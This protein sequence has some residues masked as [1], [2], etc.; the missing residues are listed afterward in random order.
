MEKPKVNIPSS[1]M[2]SALTPQEAMLERVHKHRKL[3]IGLP[4]ERAFQENRI[5]LVP[6]AVKALTKAGQRILIEQG[7]GEGAGFSDFE[8]SEAGAEIAYSGQQVFEAEVILKVAPPS[9]EEIELC[10]PGQIIISPLHLP[11]LSDEFLYRLKQ[12][13]VTALAMEYMKDSSNIFPFVRM[14]SEM[15]GISA[16]QTAAELLSVSQG[17]RGVLL[18]GISGVPPAKVIILGAGV[19]A[20]VA[21]RVALGY[22]AE[23]RVFDN[24]VRKLMRLQSNLGLKLYTGTF[25]SPELGS[26]LATADVAIG[27]IHSEIGRTPCIVSE[28]MVKQMKPGSVIVDV[29][30]DQGGCF[31]TSRVTTHSRPTFKEHEVIHYCVPNI[32]SKIPRTGSA[33]MSNILTPFFLEAG[34]PEGIEAMIRRYPGLRN[35]VYVY[36]GC[37][38]NKY[39]SERFQIK[40]TDIDLVL[41]SGF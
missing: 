13:R 35:G 26:E 15:A 10:H 29:S 33:A 19:V 2:Q 39:L 27:A 40:F 12:K 38:T 8:Y 20:E 14:M 28:D 16:M 21:T 11:T 9:L 7:A 6:A 1:L 25:S 36:K 31:A 32:V 18:G 30:I 5:A 37:V 23:V 17:G 41:T 3:V 24:S 4:K 34:S 22:G